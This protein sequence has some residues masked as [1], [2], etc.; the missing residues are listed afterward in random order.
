M[1]LSRKEYSNQ[2]GDIVHFLYRIRELS[3]LQKYCKTYKKSDS[4]IK[5]LSQINP[6]K[7]SKQFAENFYHKIIEL[8]SIF[9]EEIC[10]SRFYV[11]MDIYSNDD[12]FIKIYHY[13]YKMFDILIVKRQKNIINL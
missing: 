7:V 4:L 2:C 6:D 3:K 5:W 10:D 9:D 1:E 12:K 8:S 11:N 13:I